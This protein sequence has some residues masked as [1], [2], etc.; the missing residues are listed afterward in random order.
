MIMKNSL[1]ELNLDEILLL[2]CECDLCIIVVTCKNEENWT[3]P[4][5]LYNK[6]NR[7]ISYFRTHF[8]CE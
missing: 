1:I 4:H 5:L 7:L 3:T 8:V 6:I 2:N